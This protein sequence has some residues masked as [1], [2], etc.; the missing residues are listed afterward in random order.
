MSY[1]QGYN[2]QRRQPKIPEGGFGRMRKVQKKHAKSPDFKGLATLVMTRPVA[3]GEHIV[4]DLSSWSEPAKHQPD[5]Q[6]WA[7][8]QSL[9]ISEYNPNAQWASQAQAP[10]QQVQYPPQQP[11]PQYAPQ[12]VYAQPAPGPVYAPGPQP[13][14]HGGYAPAPGYAPPPPQPTYAPPQ[15]PSPHPQTWGGQPAQARPLQ[16]TGL[17]GVKIPF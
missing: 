7:E 1:D 17:E 4:V 9:R 16:P 3:A 8:S 14:Q 13:P 5:G 11:Q 15:A 6:V 2:G 10:Q 12:P